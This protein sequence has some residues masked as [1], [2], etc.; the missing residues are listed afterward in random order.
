MIS[1]KGRELLDW[2]SYQLLSQGGFCLSVLVGVERMNGFVKQLNRNVMGWDWLD[3]KAKKLVLCASNYSEIGHSHLDVDTFKVWK[4][5]NFLAR[6]NTHYR[7]LLFVPL[8]NPTNHFCAYECTPDIHLRITRSPNLIAVA[9]I[10]QSVQWLGYGLDGRG[11]IPGRNN[12]AILLFATASRPAKGP[13]H[14]LSNG[15]GGV[16]LGIKRPGREAERSPPPR[17]EVKNVWSGC[18]CTYT[19]HSTSRRGA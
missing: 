3:V 7:L 10:V 5:R 4:K 13:T 15:H 18:S 8:E 11:S 6:P 19:P 16:F 2:I 1:I 14:L 9:G 12:E 17:A